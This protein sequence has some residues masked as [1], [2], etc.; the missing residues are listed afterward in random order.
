MDLA[1]DI[2]AS[3]KEDVEVKAAMVVDAVVVAVDA[4]VVHLLWPRF[5]PRIVNDKWSSTKAI[6]GASLRRL[7]QMVE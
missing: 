1:V 3:S 4:S 5:A 6:M 2:K 7:I